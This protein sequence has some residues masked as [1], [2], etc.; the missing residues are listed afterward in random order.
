M[1]RQE[2]SYYNAIGATD[3]NGRLPIFVR[4]KYALHFYQYLKNKHIPCDPP[5]SVTFESPVKK[6]ER[7]KTLD[8]LIEA[9]GTQHD[10]DKWKADW[11][12]QE[13]K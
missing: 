7:Y 4:E 10:F 2:S 9:T 5:V 12:E 1:L 3:T 13:F 11:L 6:G 8:C